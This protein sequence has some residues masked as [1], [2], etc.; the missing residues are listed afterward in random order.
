MDIYYNV[1]RRVNL[2]VCLGCCLP[3]V[4]YEPR[5]YRRNRVRHIVMQKKSLS[6]T[7][8]Y[9]KNPAERRAMLYTSVATSSAIEGVIMA[10]AKPGKPSKKHKPSM[11][12]R[13]ER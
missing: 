11:T 5:E 4:D 12:A 9:L 1:F 8:P 6:K 13:R 7:N 2:L 3:S 10:E